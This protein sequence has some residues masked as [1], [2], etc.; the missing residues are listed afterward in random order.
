MTTSNSLRS[1]RFVI[2]A[3][4]A[5]D[6]LHWDLML[7]AGEVLETYRVNTPPEEWPARPVEA[8]R[9]FDHSPRF[10]EY[11]GVVNKGKGDVKIADSGRYEILEEER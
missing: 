4:D 3:H 2:L 5:P 7:E 11:E 9:I 8:E 1:G 6:G 10:L